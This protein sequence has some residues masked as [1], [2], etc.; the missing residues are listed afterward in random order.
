MDISGILRGGG[1]RVR[2]ISTQY[3]KNKNSILIN[4]RH[5]SQNKKTNQPIT[6]QHLRFYYRPSNVPKH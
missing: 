2:G 5:I 3:S 4:T 1:G 6:T